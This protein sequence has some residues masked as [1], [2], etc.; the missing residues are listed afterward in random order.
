METGNIPNSN[1]NNNNI[2]SLF[3]GDTIVVVAKINNASSRDLVP[4]F[5]L[6]QD[7]LYH[8]EGSSKHES[9]VICKQTDEP[10]GPNTEKTAKRVIQIPRDLTTTI[11]SCQI[12]MLEYH[13]KVCVL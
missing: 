11:N 2:F 13:L 10:M 12:L 4:K 9:K 8:A 1:N 5:S 6:I 7:V 3:S